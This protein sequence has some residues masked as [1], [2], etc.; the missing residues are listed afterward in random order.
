MKAPARARRAR[1]ANGHWINFHHSSSFDEC[2]LSIRNADHQP[3]G[4]LVTPRLCACCG[5]NHYELD[6]CLSCVGHAPEKAGQQP[7]SNLL[8]NGELQ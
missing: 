5:E 4:R 7:D 3:P 2:D 8:K 1:G 6:G